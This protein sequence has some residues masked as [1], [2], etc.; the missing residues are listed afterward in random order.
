[1][2]ESAVEVSIPEE[3]D[4]PPLEPPWL[5]EQRQ[6]AARRFEATGW[7][8]PSIEEWRRTDLKPYA[9]ESFLEGRAGEAA[10]SA[11]ERTLR[12][13]EPHDGLLRLRGAVCIER[14][15][16]PGLRAAGLG[17][18]PLAEAVGGANGSL[19]AILTQGLAAAD[20]RLQY[21]HYRS[22]ENGVH[23]AIPP[24]MRLGRPLYVEIEP[25]AAGGPE[26]PHVVVELGSGA[27]AT[28]VL[29]VRGTAAARSLWNMAVDIR[30][31]AHAR[32]RY[33]EYQ[34]L[35]SDALVFTHGS[36][37][38][39]EGAHLE[40]LAAIFGG[41]LHKSR[42]DCTLD[43]P[44]AQVLLNGVY[45]GDGGQHMDI[46]TIQ[47]HRSRGAYSRT[48]YTGAVKD[49]ATTVFQ[50]LIDVA[51]GASGTDAYLANRNLILGDTARSNSIPSLA[52]RNNDLRCSHGSTTSRID[53]EQ[54][55]YLMSRGLDRVEA[56]QMLVQGYFEELVSQ[57]PEPVATLTRARI[58]Q[59]LAGGG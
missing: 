2:A 45:F 51:E 54:R 33:A 58:R 18:R 29:V 26:L 20:N 35:P 15:V 4:L 9:P 28:V 6:T 39:G 7:P 13:D 3:L 21:W 17:L 52:I 1:L 34:D 16:S 37:V 25:A 57:A 31:G 44:G 55:F 47:R 42:L 22:W 23:V 11:A 38:L 12:E 24:E 10:E 19:E 32:L 14:A 48:M 43:G 53:P 30:L 27:E 41:H 40:Q 56:E 8:T 59:K 49:T 5:E 46:T 36:S 50:G